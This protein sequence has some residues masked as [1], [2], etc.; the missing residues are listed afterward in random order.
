[1]NWDLFFDII[2]WGTALPT[3]VMLAVEMI[4]GNVIYQEES[5]AVC[6]VGALT[7]WAYIAASWGL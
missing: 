2:A 4:R 6:L 5:L 7:G 1:M 3:T